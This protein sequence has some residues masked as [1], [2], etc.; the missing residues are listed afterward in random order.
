MPKSSATAYTS[1]MA[2]WDPVLAGAS[3]EVEHMG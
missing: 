2:V 3:R 1:L